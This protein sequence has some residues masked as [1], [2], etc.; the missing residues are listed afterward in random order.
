MAVPIPLPVDLSVG[1]APFGWEGNLGELFNLVQASL[2]AELDPTFLIGRI[3][4]TMPEHDIGPW[5]DGAGW[6]FF[7]PLAGQYT[8]DE[9]GCPIGT[10][11]MWGGP[12]STLPGNWLLCYG[13]EVSRFTYSLLFNQIGE[14]WGPGD[15]ATS[16][17]LPP[18][19]VFFINAAGL[20]LAYQVPLSLLPAAP[21]QTPISSSPEGVAAR[22]GA[23]TS[24]LL[25]PSDMPPLEVIL[26]F[27]TQNFA[28]ASPTNQGTPIAN[29]QKEGASFFTAQ[30]DE[31]LCDMNNNPLGVNQQPFNIMPPFVAI[32]FMIKWQ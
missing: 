12:L 19:G 1:A 29:V 31:L 32:N 22:G 5:F 20:S 21:G 3:G 17:N 11:A 24:G 7:D 6:W 9:Q 4:G 30:V 16:F 15:G 28:N 18:G 8:P 14:T 2:Q 27:Q 25:L 23:Q 26:K 10:I 13:Q